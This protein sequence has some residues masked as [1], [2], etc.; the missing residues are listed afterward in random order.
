MTPVPYARNP[1]LNSLS[2]RLMTDVTSAYTLSHTE[3]LADLDAYRLPIMIEHPLA[4]DDIRRHA[5]L[6]DRPS[7]RS[8]P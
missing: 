2:A 8:V 6:Q 3:H 5:Q 7:R 1:N 4:Q